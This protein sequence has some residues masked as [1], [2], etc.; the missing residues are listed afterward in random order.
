MVN[1]TL[2]GAPAVS[3]LPATGAY[4]VYGLPSRCREKSAPLADRPLGVQL[5][6]TPQR[7]E[8][9]VVMKKLAGTATVAEPAPAARTT[10]VSST[11][12][13][14]ACCSEIVMFCPARLAAANQATGM[15]PGTVYWPPIPGDESVTSCCAT[16]EKVA[17]L[18]VRMD[19]STFVN[20]SRT[21]HR[22]LAVPPPPPTNSDMSAT[23]DC[24]LTSTADASKKLAAG[25]KPLFSRYTARRAPETPATD[26]ETTKGEVTAT[27]LPAVG[28][29]RVIWPAAGATVMEGESSYVE[30]DESEATWSTYACP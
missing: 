23:K 15:D 5:R 2:A 6:S 20:A 9:E 26:H 21:V 1:S 25:T 17:E 4:T 29:R 18:D 8:V 12:G 22:E 27:V 10:V 24:A 7:D 19:P 14:L 11:G 28:V 30:A 16:S 13:K 3:V